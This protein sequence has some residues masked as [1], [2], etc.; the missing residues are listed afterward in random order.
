MPR[1]TQLSAW[2]ENRPGTLGRLA[3]PAAGEE[4][5]RR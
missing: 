2:V 5:V 3:D 1:V 4:A